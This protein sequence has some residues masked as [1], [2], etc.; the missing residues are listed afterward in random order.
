MDLFSAS[1]AERY[2]MSK[3]PSLGVAEVRR[4]IERAILLAVKGAY[5]S[6]R[7]P[8][9]A[10]SQHVVFVGGA[11]RSG[12]NMLMDV[13]ERSLETDVYHETDPRA[14]DDYLMRDRSVIHA[15]VDRSRAP[16]VIVKALCESQDIPEL[17]EEFKPAKAVWV[18]R[19]YADVCNSMNVSFTSHRQVMLQIAENPAAGGWRS[20]KMSNETYSEIRRL[21]GDE[22]TDATAAALQWYMRNK[23]YLDLGMDANPAVQL[24]FY[25]DLVSDPGA[26]FTRIGGFLGIES[27]EFMTRHVHAGSV[28]KRPA[29]ALSPEVKSLCDGLWN[30]FK[31]LP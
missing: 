18:I 3:K 31:A 2:G 4:R 22:L 10:D 19:H 20:A 12:T 26:T 16:C 30:R 15:L 25:E 23:L 29:P 21:I 28:R 17:I 24:V 9:N 11:Q 1:L 5:Q 14:F 27:T 13:L 7:G 6:L 8:G